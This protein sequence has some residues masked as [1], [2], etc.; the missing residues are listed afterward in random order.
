MMNAMQSVCNIARQIE[1]VSQYLTEIS[2]TLFNPEF[3]E[4]GLA[5]VYRNIALDEVEHIQLLTLE[6]TRQIAAD[7]EGQESH[8]DENTGSV[9]AQGELESSLGDKTEKQAVTPG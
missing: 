9:F 1:R 5:D 7:A 3:L 8:G 6:L 2:S 4:A